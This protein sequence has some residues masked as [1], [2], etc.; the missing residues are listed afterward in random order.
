[1]VLGLRSKHRKDGSV[2]VNYLVHV[3]EIK[4]WLPSSQSLALLWE[5]GDQTSGF[6][7]PD[8][9][10]SKVEFNKSFILPLTLRREKRDREKFQKN[11]LEFHLYEPRKDKPNKDQL[12]GSAII[13]LADYGIID[14]VLNL[15]VPISWKKSS[16]SAAQPVLFLNIQSNDKEETTSSRSSL[17]KQSSLEKYGQ[18]SASEVANEENDDELGIASFTDDEEDDYTHSSYTNHKD[19]VEGRK[20]GNNVQPPALPSVTEPSNNSS[21]KIPERS[22][23]SSKLPERSMASSKLPERSM[24]SSKLPERSMTSVRKDQTTPSPSLQSSFSTMGSHNKTIGTTTHMRTLEPEKKIHGLQEDIKDNSKLAITT[25]VGESLINAE[26]LHDQISNSGSEQEERT[27]EEKKQ[28]SEDNLVGKF[29]ASRKQ[30][31]LRSNTLVSNRKPP[32]GQV[33]GNKLKHL[34]SVQLP[35]TSGYSGNGLPLASPNRSEKDSVIQTNSNETGVQKSESLNGKSEEKSRIKMLEEE[36]RETAAIEAGLYSIVAEHG[37]STNKVHAPA[38]RLSRFYLHACK[39]N[40]QDRRVNAARA[41]SSGLV[42]VSKSCGNDVPRLTFWLSNSV[43]LRAIIIQTIGESSTGK[44]KYGSKKVHDDW[45]DPQTFLIALEKVEAWMFSRIIESVWWQT[46]TPHMQSTATNGS[47]KMIGPNSKKSPGSKN[48]LGNQQGNFSIELWKKAFKDACERLCP[49]RAGGHECGCLPVLPRL[50]MEQLVDRLDV[51]MFNA[52]L[53]ES[54]EEMPTDPLSDPIGDL[55]VLPIPAGKSSFGAGAQLKNTIGTW[56]RWLTDLFGIED[57]DI[58]E[59]ADDVIDNKK[60]PDTSFKAFRLLHALSDLMMLPFEMLADKSTRKEVCPTFSTSLIRR[61]VCTFVPDEFSPN[62]LPKS[63]IEALDEEM[64]DDVAEA[65]EESLINFP[66]IAP[67]STYK[68]PAAHSLS[69]IISIGGSQSLTRSSSSVLKK[70][71]TSDDE[72]D[73]LD[74]PLTSILADSLRVSSSS[75]GFQ[76]VPKGGRSIVRYQLL[77]QVWKDSE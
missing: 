43:M 33:P 37:S 27:Q 4:P 51:A 59:D 39:E 57:N 1:M 29:L 58:H 65:S 69:A 3:Q 10:D 19:S 21:S 15:T 23:T 26:S 14:S 55:R 30:D 8:V 50:V 22:M 31:K 70:S 47:G 64:Q 67:S 46:L 62:P 35:K 63:L 71:Y 20:Q 12:L 13:N 66:C 38:R 9:I 24:A 54:A 6:L 42:L 60:E 11:Y 41:I 49:T 76:A 34:K 74:S 16:K 53:R 48:G 18:E 40:D 5:N 77:R 36:L 7:S 45:R 52:I 75:D 25:S 44:H 17:S 56:S 2:Q 73:E 28:I 32:G 72:L 68:P 61:V